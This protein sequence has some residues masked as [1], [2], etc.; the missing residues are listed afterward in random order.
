MY[1]RNAYDKVLSVDNIRCFSLMIWCRF[2]VEVG[3]V[4]PILSLV[5]FGITHEEQ[6]ER[7][8]LPDRALTVHG[9]P[10]EFLLLFTLLF[11]LIL[12]R[13]ITFMTFVSILIISS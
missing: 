7:Q 2:R 6:V 1:T 13:N 11:L 4:F 9:R 10:G 12:A 8:L 5:L 3:F